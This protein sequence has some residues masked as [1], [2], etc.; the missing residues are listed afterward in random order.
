MSILDIDIY[1][2]KMTI[3]P[4]LTYRNNNID[5]NTVSNLL[6]QLWTILDKYDINVSNK[7][8]IYS[9]ATECLENIYK[10]SEFI[11]KEDSVSFQVNLLNN[12]IEIKSSNP[13]NINKILPICERIE[14]LKGLNN[15]SIK[16]LY[17]HKIKKRG[18]SNKGGAGL[19]L[20]LMVRKAEGKIDFRTETINKF[21]SSLVL[22]INISFT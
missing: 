5:Y 3:L 1:Q 17:L 8:K 14:F 19:G 10:H 12:S 22:T 7:K 16:Q 20:I 6:T 21:V 13:I 18:I 4:L 9:V 11:E 15:N 2:N